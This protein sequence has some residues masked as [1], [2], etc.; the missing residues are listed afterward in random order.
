L[1]L[2]NNKGH[3]FIKYTMKKSI[4][5]LED[6]DDIRELI[7]Y[8]LVEENYEVKGYPTVKEFKKIMLS[9]HPDMIVL[10]VML[11][12]GNGIDVCDELKSNE[13]T[14]DIPILMMSAHSQAY[15]IKQRCAAEDFI[16]KPFD[17]DDF[18]KR[19][20]RYLH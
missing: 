1:N 15:D 4:Y 18:V 8:L 2:P 17:I 6:N 9:S 16:S 20:D 19:V 3:L 11:A 10:D 5:I 14:N 12:D 13:R 7:S